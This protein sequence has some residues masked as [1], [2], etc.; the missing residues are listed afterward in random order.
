MN[1]AQGDRI[2]SEG[3]IDQLS[4]TFLSYV[5]A[6]NYEA[7]STVH[8]LS[9]MTPLPI[10]LAL[11]FQGANVII[12]SDQGS[13]SCHNLFQTYLL[14]VRTKTFCNIDP[15]IE[16][17]QDDNWSQN[18]LIKW[19]FFLSLSL[20]HFLFREHF[21][22]SKVIINFDTFV[23]EMEAGHLAKRQPA[24]WPNNSNHH[25]KRFSPMGVEG[26]R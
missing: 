1:T 21:P 10:Y 5:M 16:S 25:G 23:L 2:Q 26:S 13:K 6:Y 17:Q 22:P 8:R 15:R 12:T 14:L 18:C 11:F 7:W 4:K 3:F 24:K 19:T 9:K 20:C